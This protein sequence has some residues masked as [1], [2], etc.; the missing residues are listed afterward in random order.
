[1]KVRRVADVPTNKGNAMHD[2]QAK[3]TPPAASSGVD[4]DDF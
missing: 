3:Y 4:L 2:Y 1:L